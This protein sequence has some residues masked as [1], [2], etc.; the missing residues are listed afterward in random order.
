MKAAA[1]VEKILQAH[2]VVLTLGAEPTCV[3][4]R[5]LGAEWTVAATGPTKL[6][7]A[8][9]LAAHLL[10]GPLKGGL[11]VF[12]PGKLYPGEVNP[13][14]ALHV[15]ARRDGKPMVPARGAARRATE[16]DAAAF[17]GRLASRLGVTGR[18]SRLVDPL[19][20]AASVW[21]LPLD[22]EGEWDAPDWRWPEGTALIGAEGPAGLRL[23]WDKAEGSGVRRALTVG[24]RGG[25][26][27]IFLP[28]LRQEAW[29]ALLA[30]V[31][32]ALPAGVGADF[33]GYVPS[34]EARCWRG[35]VL[36]ADPGV[37]E[38]NSPPCATWKEYDDWLQVM[39]RAQR[40]CGLVT[41]KR[42]RDG[43]T[44]GTGGGHHL[45]FGGPPGGENP[46]FTRPGWIV[47]ILRFWQHHPSLSY[48]F[49]GPYV[50]SSS[51]APRIDEAAKNLS[52]LEMAY[53]WLEDLPAGQDHRFALA[54]TL[55]HLHSDVSG[56]TH[57][58]EIS[59]DK[60]WNP[61]FPG[62]A[63]GLI[64]FRAIESFPHREWASAVALLWRA[65]AAHLLARPFRA[66]LRDFGGSLHDRCFLPSVLWQDFT[67]VL[68]GLE[69]GGIALDPGIFRKIWDWRFPVL[70]R[71]P[72]GVVVRRALEAWPLLCETPL[73]G[74]STSRFV[75]TSI[76]RLEV[77]APAGGAV[78]RFNGRKLPLREWR[79]G[80][81]VAGLRFRSSALRPSLHPGVP[82]QL[83]LV[84]EIEGP[85]GAGVFAMKGPGERFTPF[86][87]RRPA[88]GREC[89][90]AVGAEVCCDLRLAAATGLEG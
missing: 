57:R 3:P 86:T 46:F 2:G 53:A 10:A 87:G 85:R 81:S 34:D 22:H 67:A 49:T 39:D 35:L 1:A 4:R 83:P 51:Q 37:L 79:D 11:A 20:R 52:D 31:G 14:W 77:L 36:S 12:A 5:P 16:A 43:R 28:P 38:I 32:R 69:A 40:A 76:E 84:L 70:L 33:A 29:S 88:R 7:F 47:S 63:R 75:D 66:A 58:A 64:E 23:P 13:R 27:E 41:S 6:K 60:F 42:E 44:V 78:V 74:G 71:A 56:N 55:L 65:L 68:A 15:L 48:I 24:L 30:A 8:R 82:V 89:R 90:P 73:E 19:R 59:F 50:G 45:L 62:G 61:Q 80:R 26:F 18:V 72:G 25:R 17:P 54:D 9:K 21:V